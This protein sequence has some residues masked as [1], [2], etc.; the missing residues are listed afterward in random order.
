MCGEKPTGNNAA[1]AGAGSPPHVRGKDAGVS[2]RR[3]RRG[4]T[5]ACAGKSRGWCIDQMVEEDHPR[6][7]GEKKVA[8]EM[9]RTTKGSPPHV[10]GK[11]RNN[12][13]FDLITG[14]IPACA[15]KRVNLMA[16][17]EMFRDHPRVCGEKF[18]ASFAPFCAAGSPPHVRGKGTTFSDAT[19]WLR[20]TPACAGKSALLLLEPAR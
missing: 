14:I 16:T 1:A 6:M 20:I 10:R 12:F 9:G 4:I 11:A 7:C 8:K 13:N 3:H 18:R 15:G 5:P 19:Q 2:D 17:S